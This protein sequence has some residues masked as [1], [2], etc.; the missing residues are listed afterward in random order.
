MKSVCVS[1]SGEKKNL[2][3]WNKV[4]QKLLKLPSGSRK[5]LFNEWLTKK[6]RKH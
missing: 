6:T 5:D 2:K 3:T 4:T 1:L